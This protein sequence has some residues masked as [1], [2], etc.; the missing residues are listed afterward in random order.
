MGSFVVPEFPVVAA[1]ILGITVAGIVAYT[2]FA[3]GS[4]A[5]FFGRT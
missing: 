1:L 3:K 2:R 5:G 4:T